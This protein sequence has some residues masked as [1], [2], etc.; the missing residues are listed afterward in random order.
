MPKRSN[1][2]GNSDPD[3]AGSNWLREF[4]LVQP[5]GRAFGLN[6]FMANQSK[7][8]KIRY[9]LIDRAKWVAIP[10]LFVAMVQA[11]GNLAYGQEAS[12]TAKGLRL[13]CLKFQATVSEGFE[14]PDKIVGTVAL[15]N[16]ALVNYEKAL[17]TVPPPGLANEVGAIG[18]LKR[19]VRFIRSEVTAAQRLLK[20]KK[21]KGQA[22]QKLQLLTDTANRLGQSV[23]ASLTSAL[24]PSCPAALFLGSNWKVEPVTTTTI[25][26]GP[27]ITTP[28]Q[29]EAV[30][31]QGSQPIASATGR[32][33]VPM[34]LFPQVAGYGYIDKRV[35]SRAADDVYKSTSAAYLGV[36]IREIT[37]YPPRRSYGLVVAAVFRPEIPE[38]LRKVGL[39][40]IEGLGLD[41][42]PSVNGFRVYAA[43]IE[44][45]QKV[46]AI[47]NEILLDFTGTEL[48]SDSNL[49][50]FVNKM[51]ALYGPG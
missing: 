33:E 29:S 28:A 24:L 3:I 30:T 4:C 32:P 13:A 46:V 47:R 34:Y 7:S 49:L 14:R 38:S 27:P 44:G 2:P 17:S 10:L 15:L 22:I 8:R 6:R 19:Y 1:N 12:E 37:D 25:R 50:E 18:D 43:K 5:F 40:E 35:F 26:S 41:T 42:A 21:S 39:Q 51:L 9:P 20:V 16:T 36:T 31:S 11:S 48:N 23:D 45:H